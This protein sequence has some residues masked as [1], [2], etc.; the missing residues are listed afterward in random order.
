MELLHPQIEILQELESRL[1][2]GV[3]AP[4]ESRDGHAAFWVPADRVHD[5][6]RTL[7]SEIARPFAMLFDLTAIDER[8]RRDR[9]VAARSDFTLVYELLSFDRPYHA[10]LKVALDGDPPR[11]RS[12]TGLWPCA[13]W[14]EREVW[15]MFGIGFEGH[16]ALRRILMP[17]TWIGHPLRKDHP[18]RATELGPYRMTEEGLEAEEDASRFRPEA[19][20]LPPASAED[21]YLFLNLGPQHPGTHGVLRIALQLD[22]EEIVNAIPILGFHHRAAEKMAERQTWHTYIPYTDRIDYL[23]GVNNNLPYLLAVERLAGIEV[24]A[25]AQVIRVLLCELFRIASHLVW[26]GTFAQ[27]VGQLSPVFYMFT[28]REQVLRIIEAICGFRLHPAWF[29]IG[30]VAHDLPRGWDDLVRDFLRIFPSRLAEYD[31]IVMRNSLFKART[32]GVGE[33]T[34][35]EAIEWGVTGPNLRAC[36]FAWDARKKRPYAGYERFDFDVPSATRGDCYGRAQVRVEEMRQSLRIVEQ[37][38]KRMPPGPYRALHPL[39]TPP[40]KE[41]A[42][43]DIETLIAHFLNVTWGPAIPAG[44]AAATVEGAK[45]LYSYYAVSDGAP[46]PYRVRIRAPSFAHLQ[47]IGR[48]SRG[49]L[50]ADLLA[51]LGSLD[52]VLGEI[53]R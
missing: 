14:Y 34:R 46:Q 20:G 33:Y 37:C 12:V 47:T 18:A 23:S 48:I 36:D 27:D 51:N 41:K 24:P 4:Q 15:D 17:D 31:G 8:T 52:Y 3:V 35:A 22:G 32:V 38:L 21:E 2:P 9:A 1:G 10:R 28:D 16:P 5:V 50:V 11:A 19:W 42:L 30:G 7:K 13:S 6:L 29:R 44:E 53:D 43:Q 26:Y 45:G 39:A 49:H 40:I 25:R